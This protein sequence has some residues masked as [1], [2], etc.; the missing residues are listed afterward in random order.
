M[1]Q[2]C[3]SHKIR[4]MENNKI[5]IYLIESIINISCEFISYENVDGKI[6]EPTRCKFINKVIK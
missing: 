4:E 5:C 6:N 1:I 3:F 2:F